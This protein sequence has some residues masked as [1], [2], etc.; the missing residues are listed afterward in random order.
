MCIP[1]NRHPGSQATLN[2]HCCAQGFEKCPLKPQEHTREVIAPPIKPTT[3]HLN[4]THILKTQDCSAKTRPAQS[5][6]LHGQAGAT[7][8]STGWANANGMH[9]HDKQT[10]RCHGW[11][12]PR[13]YDSMYNY[14]H[15]NRFREQQIFTIHFHIHTCQYEQKEIW[16]MDIY[17]LY[18]PEETDICHVQIRIWNTVCIKSVCGQIVCIQFRMWKR[19]PSTIPYTEIHSTH[20]SIYGNTLCSRFPIWKYIPCAILSADICP[21]CDSI[22]RNIFQ[23]Q[24]RI[25]KY[26][27]LLKE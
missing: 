16:D 20:D 15:R 25:Y 19:T 3:A 13:T 21:I 23:I 1:V 11:A 10:N 17:F 14:V 2:I 27:N 18:N 8:T 12:R 24:F 9:P 22:Y 7:T 26:Y 5:G 6:A 4:M